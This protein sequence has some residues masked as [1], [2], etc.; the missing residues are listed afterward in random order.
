MST[1]AIR[2]PDVEFSSLQTDVSRHSVKRSA[3]E[4]ELMTDAPKIRPFRAEREFGLIVGG[5]LLL[6]TAWWFYRG[7]FPIVSRG[8]LIIGAILVLLG[9][10][11]PRVLKW[12]K[13]GLDGAGSAPRL[14]V[15]AHS[16]RASVLSNCD[17]D[18]IHQT[19]VRLGSSVTASW[20]ERILLA[21]ILR[22]PAKSAPLRKDVLRSKRC[23][24]HKLL[25]SCGSS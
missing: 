2:C 17:A 1:F 10:A 15:V 14:V 25:V 20:F 8:T 7:K 5:I 24:R 6:L 9:L 12:P 13:Q 21:A 18:W 23:L 4:D 11:W 19:A 3:H 16:P 22:A